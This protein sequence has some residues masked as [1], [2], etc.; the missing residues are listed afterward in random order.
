MKEEIIQKQS[1]N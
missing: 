1:K